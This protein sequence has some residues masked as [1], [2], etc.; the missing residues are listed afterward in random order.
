M[1][2]QQ[3][4]QFG[5]YRHF[6]FFPPFWVEFQLGFGEDPDGPQLRIEI[7]PEQLHHFL[8]PKSREQERPPRWEANDRRQ[9]H[10]LFNAFQVGGAIARQPPRLRE[11]FDHGIAHLLP[12]DSYPVHIGRGLAERKWHRALSLNG[13]VSHTV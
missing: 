7:L 5:R 3:L 1:A 12:Q 11:R 4:R 10:R 2:F 13:S 9:S 6:A 8:F